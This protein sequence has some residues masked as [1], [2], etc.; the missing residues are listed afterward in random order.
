MGRQI[1]NVAVADIDLGGLMGD[2]HKHQHWDCGTNG[3]I[4]DNAVDKF[5]R[6]L[7]DPLLVHTTSSRLCGRSNSES[8]L[9]FAGI[10]MNNSPGFLI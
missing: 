1:F 5:I 8:R 9:N 6:A 3:L 7:V 10:R 2:F 4:P